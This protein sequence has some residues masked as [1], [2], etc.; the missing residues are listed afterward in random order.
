MASAALPHNRVQQNQRPRPLA[1]VDRGVA[2][3]PAA[4][5]LGGVDMGDERL[6]RDGPGPPPRLSRRPGWRRPRHAG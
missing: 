1:A 3:P 4:V 2:R 6:A 5:V